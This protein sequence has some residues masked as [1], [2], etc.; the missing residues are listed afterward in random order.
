MTTIIM[1]II[2]AVQVASHEPFTIEAHPQCQSTDQISYK[3][4]S[5][6]DGLMCISPDRAYRDQIFTGGFER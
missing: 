2:G 5:P 6:G 3:I 4:K 1:I